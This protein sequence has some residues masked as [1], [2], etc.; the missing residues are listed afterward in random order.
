MKTLHKIYLKNFYKSVG[1][2]YAYIVLF[3]LASSH[4]SGIIKIIGALLL[5]VS[6]ATPILFLNSHFYSNIPYLINRP[7]SKKDLFLFFIFLRTIKLLASVVPIILIDNV[8]GYFRI[9]TLDLYSI[10]ILI[11]GLFAFNYIGPIIA[12]NKSKDDSL[13]NFS[14]FF[15]KYQ[16]KILSLCAAFIFLAPSIIDVI[17]KNVTTI[18]LLGIFLLSIIFLLK[19]NRLFIIMPVRRFLPTSFLLAAFTIS[20]IISLL[21][22]D[23]KELINKKLS[24]DEQIEKI[25]ALWEYSPDIPKD[26]KKRL[27]VRSNLEDYTLLLDLGFGRNLTFDEFLSTAMTINKLHKTRDYL[28]RIK[29]VKNLKKYIS[30]YQNLIQITKKLESNY[31]W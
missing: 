2:C 5:F 13:R 6:L 11:A 20:P 9:H 26:Q 14:L 31:Q 24:E 15:K 16:K 8:Y 3:F 29:T 4:I 22:T 21:F 17:D 7:Y 18:F 10:Y 28:P 12:V 30:S 27:L 1:F 23:Y 19:L 25:L